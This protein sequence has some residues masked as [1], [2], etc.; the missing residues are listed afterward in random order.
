MSTVTCDRHA[1]LFNPKMPNL[2][3]KCHPD[4]GNLNRETS[5]D[6]KNVSLHCGD[7]SVLCDCG[8]RG[9]EGCEDAVVMTRQA[10]EADR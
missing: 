5:G 3:Q 7:V 1:A 8:V 6:N 10:A 4:I 2:F 9:T